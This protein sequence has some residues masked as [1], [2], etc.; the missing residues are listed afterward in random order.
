M[1]R[2]CLIALLAIVLP[3]LAGAQTA[4]PLKHTPA[5]TEPS[6]TARDLETRLYI[7][8]DDSMQGREAGTIGTRSGHVPGWGQR[9]PRPGMPKRRWSC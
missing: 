7:F 8:A 6:I 1:S 4:L 3:T 2:P 5:P 9:R